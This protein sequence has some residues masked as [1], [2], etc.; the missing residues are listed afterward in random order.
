MRR[1]DGH[2]HCSIAQYLLCLT[3]LL[4]VLHRAL[5]TCENGSCPEAHASA[6][7]NGL[8]GASASCDQKMYPRAGKLKAVSTDT[9]VVDFKWAGAPHEFDKFV[10]ALTE[11]GDDAFG[12]R[13]WYSDDYGKDGTWKDI[14]DKLDGAMEPADPDVPETKGIVDIHMAAEHPKQILFQGAGYKHWITEDF[15]HTFKSVETPGRTLGWWNDIKLHP[16]R[17]QWILAKTQ[18]HEC[19]R[20]DGATS[21]W[22]AY[23]LFVSEN[24]GVHWKN[25]TESSSGAI[26]SFWDFDWGARLHRGKHNSYPDETI[27]ATAYESA[28]HM[29]GPYPGWDKDIHFVMS[30]DFFKSA[31]TR[32]ASC[33]NQF[34]LVGHIMYL[35][36]P[37]DCPVEPDGSSRFVPPGASS[38]N[39]VLYISEDEGK[40]FT[41]SCLPVKWMDLGYNLLRT[42]DSDAAFLIVDHDEED[43]VSARAPIS[44]VYAPGYNS[45]LFTL[46]LPRNYRQHFVTDLARVEGLPGIFMANQLSGERLHDPAFVH[47]LDYDRYVQ[48]K[49]TF[50][51]GAHWQQL[52]VPETFR[53]GVCDRCRM[54]GEAN[55][56]LHLHGPSSWHEGPDGRPSFYSHENVPGIIMAVGN[57]GQYLDRAADSMCTWLSRDGGYSWEDVMP[58][59]AIYEFGDYGGLILMAPHEIEAPTDKI[60]F[61]MDQGGC[62][63]TILLEEAIDVQNIRVEPSATSHIFVVHGKACKQTPDQPTC[64]G[65]GQDD[66]PPG[67]M[68]VIDIKDVMGVDWKDCQSQD[69][70]QWSPPTPEICLLG[71]N[72]TYERRKRESM[73]FNGKEYSRADRRETSCLCDKE[74]VECEYGYEWLD[75]ECLPIVGLDKQQCGALSG[76]YV[77][78][79]T[80]RRLVHGDVCIN[81]SRVI[82]DTDGRGH[83][84]FPNTGRPLRH[85]VLAA[86]FGAVVAVTVV[87]TGVAVWWL[88]FASDEQKA[89]IEETLSPFTNAVSGVTHALRERVAGRTRRTS[90]EEA[91]FQPLAGGEEDFGLDDLDTPEFTTRV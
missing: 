40:S 21:K 58:G 24:F 23:D 47:D 16:N 3:A 1:G 18:R 5:G 78:S 27:F 14:T 55:C 34:E 30:H 53:H 26:A 81:V 42:H 64:S 17:P 88:S 37:S 76:S 77:E 25:L 6:K 31:H 65:S 91:F 60:H 12:G 49:V 28:D 56:Q 67:R 4:V 15:G 38:S 39:V 33:G 71:K 62:W 89:S 50:N 69:Y 83:L 11:P 13:L 8:L 9:P 61:S 44:N 29:K 46:S 22:C 86:I 59:A 74:D 32:V 68:Y 20:A 82:M 66:V 2:V 70:E 87:V 79:V 73:C 75:G 72:F 63:H 85:S 52:R 35:A 84:N 80:H 43:M 41:Q 19:N 48:T 90:V 10:F 51:G 7:A 57:T 45:S 54:S 36:L